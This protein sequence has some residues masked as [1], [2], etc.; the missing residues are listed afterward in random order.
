LL[1]IERPVRSCPVFPRPPPPRAA[2]PAPKK[3]PSNSARRRMKAFYEFRPAPA[4]QAG[5][6]L[7]LAEKWPGLGPTRRAQPDRYPDFG[8]ASLPPSRCASSRGSGR[9]SLYPVT[10]AQPPPIFTGF[11]VIWLSGLPVSPAALS[12]N[13]PF[14]VKAGAIGKWIFRSNPRPTSWRTGQPRV[15]SATAPG[16]RWETGR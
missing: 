12:K 6:I 1:L 4:G 7:L 3:K 13:V 8:L 10:V 14:L 11:P 5:L 2:W 15:R 9:G 16:T